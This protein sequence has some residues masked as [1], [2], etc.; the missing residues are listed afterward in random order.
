M[1]VCPN[2]AM[3]LDDAAAQPDL[4]WFRGGW[5]DSLSVLWKNIAEGR[6]TAQ[7]AVIEG[8]PSPGGSIY[9]PLRLAPGETRT[10]QLV[11]LAAHT[12][13]VIATD[14]GTFSGRDHLLRIRR[15]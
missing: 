10:V 2:A 14:L 3:W 7:P 8:E 12:R 5:F 11:P 4:A 6:V 9:L 15:T 13:A 1:E